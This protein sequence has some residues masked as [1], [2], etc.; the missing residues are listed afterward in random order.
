MSSL[1]HGKLCDSACMPDQNLAGSL[2]L[3]YPCVYQ[4]MQ[5]DTNRCL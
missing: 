2:Q 5:T 4:T 3:N 1:L